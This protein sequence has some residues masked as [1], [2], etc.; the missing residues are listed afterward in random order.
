MELEEGEV[1]Q[2]NAAPPE[3]EHERHMASA[4]APE[5][6]IDL[7]RKLN[8]TNFSNMASAGGDCSSSTAE[9]MSSRWI[10]NEIG[11]Q[12]EDCNRIPDELKNDDGV[13]INSQ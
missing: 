2:E 9:I 12:I 10:E 13:Q 4:P 6:S 7:N 8:I 1:F 5:P 3:I 11:F